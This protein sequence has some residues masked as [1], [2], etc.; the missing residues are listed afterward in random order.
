MPEYLPHSNEWLGS[1]F[2]NPPWP[3]PSSGIAAWFGPAPRLSTLD[4]GVSY[5]DVLDTQQ[6]LPQVTLAPLTELPRPLFARVQIRVPSGG[7]RDFY[8]SMGY[9]TTPPGWDHTGL[10]YEDAATFTVTTDQ[11]EIH[12]VPLN[13]YQDGTFDQLV[14]LIDN[15]GPT[16]QINIVVNHYGTFANPTPPYQVSFIGIYIGGRPIPLQ[17]RQRTDELGSSGVRPARGATTYQATNR[18]RGMI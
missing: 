8:A 18:A 7:P 4:A 17:W 1:Y 13:F 11:W 3:D 5:M 12:D 6:A 10:N 15:Y 14:W 2:Y 16:G 9:E